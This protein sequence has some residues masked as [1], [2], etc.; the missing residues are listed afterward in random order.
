ML[1]GEAGWPEKNQAF[2]NP[3]PQSMIG[4]EVCLGGS[5]Q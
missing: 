1:G 5:L 2:C 4:M 3:A